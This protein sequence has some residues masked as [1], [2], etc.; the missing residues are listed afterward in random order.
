VR[1]RFI[2][3]LTLFL[4]VATLCLLLL[5]VAGY[6]GRLHKLPELASHFKL[7]YL[8]GSLACLLLFL[9]LHSSWSWPLVATLCVVINAAAIFPLYVSPANAG[10][11]VPPERRLRLMLANVNYANQRYE[12]LID[13]VGIEQPDVLVLQEVS[14]RWITQLR[15]LESRY[16]FHLAASFDD[17]G[18]GIALYSRL[19]LEDARIVRLGSV[20]DVERPGITA[21]VRVGDERLSLLTIHPRAPLLP[22]HF[23]YRN[24]QLADAARFVRDLPVPHVFVGDLNTTPWS[25]YY[26]DF[27]ARSG[28]VDARRGS[29]ILPSFPTF[30]PFGAL[31]RLPIDH[32]FVD[33]NVIVLS[34]KTGS[35]FGSDHLPLIVELGLEPTGADDDIDC[36]AVLKTKF[37]RR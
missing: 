11:N 33:Q 3:L 16:P 14:E 20:E 35:E 34:I 29:G 36:D 6:A 27:I 24:E 13:L 1:R 23:E 26:K 32:C 10:S 17:D 18:S 7:Q 4:Q 28:L 21:R 25:P 9:S 31:L 12:R 5:S 8:L 22:N 30:L 37:K 2:K 15:S 19:P